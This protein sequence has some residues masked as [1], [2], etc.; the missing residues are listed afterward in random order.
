MGCPRIEPSPSQTLDELGLVR[1]LPRQ[2]R[3]GSFKGLPP[4]YSG[5]QLTAPDP[6]RSF[7]VILS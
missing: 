4:E 2:L 7:N 1:F 6:D 5:K 3:V